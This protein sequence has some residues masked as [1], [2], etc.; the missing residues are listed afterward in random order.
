LSKVQL[1]L[2]DIHPDGV[3]HL[4]QLLL[5][6]IHPDGMMVVPAS[7]VAA[8]LHLITGADTHACVVAHRHCFLIRDIEV[9][10]SVSASVRSLEVHAALE[11]LR[12][13]CVAVNGAAPHICQA[14]DIADEGQRML[15][16]LGI[17]AD[18]S[19]DGVTWARVNDGRSGVRH[20]RAADTL[21]VRV[22]SRV[23]LGERWKRNVRQFSVLLSVPRSFA[24]DWLDNWQALSSHLVACGAGWRMRRDWRVV[25]A[26]A[27]FTLIIGITHTKAVP[28]LA[29]TNFLGDTTV[30][31]IARNSVLLANALQKAMDNLKGDPLPL[32][33]TFQLHDF[34]NCA[35][36]SAG[37][38]GMVIVVNSQNLIDLQSVGA[39]LLFELGLLRVARG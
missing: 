39:C 3:V 1:L 33:V 32:A 11:A 28:L 2:A 13:A 9:A 19:I 34:L 18:A 38:L 23:G 8:S 31:I 25:Q 14:V 7:R 24:W 30:G 27:W 36:V 6:D 17:T 21:W 26:K 22:A 10:L 35:I 12:L 29:V 4:V 5:A 15:T 16:S 20:L 37:S